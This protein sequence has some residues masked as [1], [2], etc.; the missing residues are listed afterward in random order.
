MSTHT[1]EGFRSA[2]AGEAR[3]HRQLRPALLAVLLCAA[4]AASAQIGFETRFEVVASGD[5]TGPRL[6]DGQPDIQGHWSNTIGNQDNFTDP[7]GGIPGD[8]FRAGGGGAAAIGSQVAGADRAARAPSRVSDPADG[9]LPFQPWARRKQEELLANFFNPVREEYI[10]P[11]ARCAPAGPIKSLYWHGY[12]VRQF[13]NYI[14]FLFNS[15]TRII[16]LDDKPH[17]PE[18]VK[19]WN[20]DSRGRWE[21]NTLVVEVRNNNGKA[22][23]A[24]TGEFHGENARIT[25][26]YI[27]DNDGRRYTYRATVDDPEVFTRPWEVTIPAVRYDESSTQRGWHYAPFDAKHE[28]SEPIH[29]VWERSCVENNAGHGQLARPAGS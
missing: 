15:G 5:W 21:G 25:E 26:R 14:V 19:L 29:E 9:Q 7:Q 13:P 24:R 2:A 16:H 28:G 8:P 4:G 6:P 11:L 17:L 10:E 12:E 22:R 3:R 1:I 20:G 23:L 27:F 18:Q